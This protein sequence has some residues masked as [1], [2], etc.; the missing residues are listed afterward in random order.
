MITRKIRRQEVYLFIMHILII[1]PEQIPVP[2]PIGGSVE[3]SIYQIARKISTK[4]R[5]TIISRLRPNY[6]KRSILG[7]I[8]IIRVA[9]SNKRSYLSNVVHTVKGDLSSND[10]Q[11]TSREKSQR[12]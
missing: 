10:I 2:P 8:T 4:H 6:P 11:E 9:G 3:H 5:V 7:H 12:C 1:A